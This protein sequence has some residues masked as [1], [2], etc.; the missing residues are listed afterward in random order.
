MWAD[1]AA[2]GLSNGLVLEFPGAGHGIIDATPCAR[3]IGVDFI[4]NPLDT[5]D[6][7]CLAQIGP[8][9]FYVP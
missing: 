1:L 7:T 8:P 9:E 6:T 5:P 2:E 4:N 3:E